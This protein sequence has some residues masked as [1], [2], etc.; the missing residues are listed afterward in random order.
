VTQ[1]RRR[2]IRICRPARRSVAA[3]RFVRFVKHDCG[4]SILEFSITFSVVLLCAFGIIECSMALYC[5]HFVANAAKEATRYAMV[6]GSS[7]N[8]GA[9]TA[10]NSFSCGA[11]STDVSSFV[12]S[13]IPPGIDDSKL[14]VTTTWPGTDPSGN[15]CDTEN[16]ANSPTCVVNVQVNYSFDFLLP[17]LPANTIVLSGN[18][19]E[20]ITE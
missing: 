8:N 5:D 18:S 16:G 1:P 11:S 9:C 13:I 6:R 19:V 10:Y 15:T 2:T 17:F 20:V 7:W 12:S 3:D 4:S 14:T